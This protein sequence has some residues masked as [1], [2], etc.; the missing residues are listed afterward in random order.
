MFGGRPEDQ[1]GIAIC[2]ELDRHVPR[3]KDHQLAC[4]DSLR[5]GQAALAQRHPG[6][7]VARGPLIAPGLSGL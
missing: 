5:Q 7:D 1:V 6:D 3:A 2:A 4:F